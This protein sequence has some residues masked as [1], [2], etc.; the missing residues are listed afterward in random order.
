MS[1]GGIIVIIGGLIFAVAGWLAAHYSARK[2]AT[3]RLEL[4]NERARAKERE[5]NDE[6]VAVGNQIYRSF[7]PAVLDRNPSSKL[8]RRYTG[9]LIL[10]SV[11]Y[12]EFTYPTSKMIDEVDIESEFIVPKLEIGSK[13]R[14]SIYPISE[15]VETLFPT[16][17]K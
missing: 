2:I 7:D 4:N 9:D 8:D 14:T 1:V 11:R 16:Y 5:L 13:F 12:A 3:R 15:T 6:I 10:D 17:R